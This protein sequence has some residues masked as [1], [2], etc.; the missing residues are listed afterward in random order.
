MVI[1]CNGSHIEYRGKN[2]E[3]SY[4]DP[5]PQ[6]GALRLYVRRRQDDNA[7]GAKGRSTVD[8]NDD[9]VVDVIDKASDNDKNEDVESDDEV[10]ASENYV[11][12][13]DESEEAALRDSSDDSDDDC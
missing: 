2:G 4:A 10:E 6:F 1:A 13:R 3:H 7:P 5:M 8:E 9:S 11:S 12:D